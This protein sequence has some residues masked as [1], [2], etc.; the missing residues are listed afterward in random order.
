LNLQD[1]STNSSPIASEASISESSAARA[2]AIVPI[3]D[4]QLECD[5]T[6]ED[7]SPIL[8]SES[9]EHLICGECVRK[10]SILQRY[11]GTKGWQMVIPT[12]SKENGDWK[13]RWKVVGKDI[14]HDFAPT[15]SPLSETEIKSSTESGSFKRKASVD[16]ASST[17]KKQRLDLSTTSSKSKRCTAPSHNDD[18]QL[19]FRSL[20][21]GSLISGAKGDLFLVAG[22]KEAMCCC[23]EVSGHINSALN[24][25]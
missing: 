23:V 2:S 16:A 18:A 12:E 4:N 17:E 9:Y 3:S 20:E 11:A 15:G 1:P 10:H 13:T 24:R 19:I 5:S 25:R 8:P 7:P 22:A 6:D 14:V 21:D